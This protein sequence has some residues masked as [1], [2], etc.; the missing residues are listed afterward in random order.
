M[1][2]SWLFSAKQHVALLFAICCMLLIGCKADDNVYREYSCRFIFDTSLHPLPCQ[3]TGILGHPG[4]FCKIETFF[5][6]GVRNLRTT[7]NYDG[8]VENVPITTERESQLS[9]ILGAGNCLIIGT[10][11]YDSRLVVYEGQCS[12]CLDNYGGNSY[13]MTW[14]NGGQQLHC[15]KCGRTYD[16][17]NGVVVSGDAGREL[18][19][20]IVAFDGTVLHAWN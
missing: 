7:R 8:A 16:V 5:I 13:P 19:S 9:Y 18:Y 14:Q 12:N 10:T 6:K 4:H 2:C 1:R 3:L 11:S 15:A 17:N 20:Y